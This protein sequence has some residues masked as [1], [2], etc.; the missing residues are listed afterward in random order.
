MRKDVAFSLSNPQAIQVDADPVRCAMDFRNQAKRLSWHDDRV[1]L[2]VL[3]RF[4]ARPSPF[5]ARPVSEQPTTRPKNLALGSID[6]FRGGEVIVRLSTTP[7]RLARKADAAYDCLKPWLVSNGVP[8]WIESDPN[9]PVRA[10]FEGL[11]QP[12]QRLILLS[13][14]GI[15]QCH[16]V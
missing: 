14:A 8:S 12:I 9:Q 16:S 2:C 13:Q 4:Q 5:G 7:L 11:I 15:D 6:S 10:L 3:H 1:K